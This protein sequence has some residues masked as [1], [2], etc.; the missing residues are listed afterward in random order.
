[1]RIGRRMFLEGALM[2]GAGVISPSLTT[3]QPSRPLAR[4]IP[5]SREAIAA[6]G[7]GS[8]DHFQCRR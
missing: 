8:L 1:M 7:L 5:S 4:Q 6:V 2:A 3:A